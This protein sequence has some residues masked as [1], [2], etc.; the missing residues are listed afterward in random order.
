[1]YCIHTSMHVYVFACVNVEARERC[2][3]SPTVV[4][5]I[6]LRQGF[7]LNRKLTVR[8]GG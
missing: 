8:V 6:T 4:C 1:M 7:L 2:Q 5:L 3:K